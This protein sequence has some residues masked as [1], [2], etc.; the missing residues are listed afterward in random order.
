LISLIPI[1]ANPAGRLEARRVSGT[2][3][4]VT[5]FLV[6]AIALYFMSW[7][8]ESAGFLSDDAAYLLM[9][10]GFNPF[11]AAAPGLFHYVMRQSLFPP[12][13]PLLLGVLGGGSSTLLWDHVITTTT[14]VLA[15][16][17]Y[18][19][20]IHRET[21]D[22]LAVVAL[23]AAF[24]LLPGTLLQNL[25]ILSES[26]YLLLSLL[27][28][29]LAE[30][31]ASTRRGYGLIAVCVGLAAL[32]RTAGF[33]LILAM[34]VW[35]IARRVEG[36]LKWLLL[37]VAPSLAWMVVKSLVFASHGGGYQQLWLELLDQFRGRPPLE[38]IA[39]FLGTQGTAIWQGLLANL[40]LRPS[41]PAKI[42]LGLTLAAGLPVWLSR[43]RSWQLDAWYLLIGGAMTLCYPFPS[44]FMRLLLPWIPI[45]LLY[46]YLGA[47]SAAASGA[48]ARG[49]PF[50]GYAYLAALFVILAPSLG[51][52]AQ[53]AAEPVD[54]E[55]AAWKHTRYWYRLQDMDAI[56][57]DVAFRRNLVDATRDVPLWV[58][59][60]DCVFAVHTAIAML[61]GRRIFEQ[62]PGPADDTLQ[63]EEGARLCPYFLLMSA[64]GQV[65][66][67]QVEAFYP[68]ARLPEDRIEVV[69]TWNDPHSPEVTT[70]ILLR[71]KSG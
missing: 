71:L 57:A 56:R 30:H 50:L 8:S 19:L 46:A 64:P 52:I 42:L 10:D 66:G 70:A 41:L 16:L 14:L 33:S 54:A 25:E 35:S 18:G 44:F 53:R 38:F 36:R 48:A 55:L 62:P 15:L 69:R 40:D 37:A 4:L 9:A 59:E 63:F 51:F 29:C 47:R 39:Q 7:N 32:T 5:V 13:Y 28:L 20:W 22:R 2:I 27:A 49:A 26:P 45:L 43:L 1:L 12:L 65:G 23:V 21:G 68:S 61:Y 17:V 34:G 60:N 31:T 58:P 11:R 3:A 24:S 6:L 67:R